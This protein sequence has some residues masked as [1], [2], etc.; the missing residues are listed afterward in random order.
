[1]ALN[2]DYLNRIRPIEE[3]R[4]TVPQ[5]G[6]LS[7][8]GNVDDFN[9]ANSS[10][11]QNTS[12]LLDS[13]RA[14]REANIKE[15]QTP[16]SE[17][18][19]RIEMAKREAKE[20][21]RSY[22]EDKKIKNQQDLIQLKK[23][24]LD[25]NQSKDM[26][27]VET[28]RMKNQRAAEKTV[29]DAQEKYKQAENEYVIKNIQN[30][31][32]PEEEAF[33]RNNHS[34][35]NGRSPV[36]PAQSVQTPQEQTDGLNQEPKKPL[37]VNQKFKFRKD[38]KVGGEEGGPEI[39]PE[40]I[41]DDWIEGRSPIQLDTFQQ[42]DRAAIQ[43]AIRKRKEDLYK[44]GDE[45]DKLKATFDGKTLGDTESNS[46]GKSIRVVDQ[47][48]DIRNAFKQ[49]KTDERGFI[50]G[51]DA[52][53]ILGRLRG[54][55]PY[56]KSAKEIESMLQAVVPNMA[57]GIYGEV[58]VLTDNDIKNYK[59]ILPKLSD[60]ND[61]KD[62]LIGISINQA[63]NSILSNLKN[64]RMQGKNVSGYVELLEDLERR[65][66]DLR[67]GLESKENGSTNQSFALKHPKANTA[68]EWAKANQNDPRSAEILKR[69][70]V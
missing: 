20:K 67:S 45:K 30:P 42:K 37:T 11:S 21:A 7:N 59:Q 3:E 22:L 8:A 19:F 33:L 65:E 50:F 58:G 10:L 14:K 36:N 32:D 55:N 62:A 48:E 17:K 28:E 31:E 2:F 47:L 35:L 49:E 4:S 60:P 34:K 1:M 39:S 56:D 26:A 52:S 16:L 13:M 24:E 51:I 27:D 53:P 6:R 46:L 54:W 69:L 63:R 15:G 43:S 23:I 5:L 68:L 70:G 66:S 25:Y 41:V 29:F 38:I 9:D 12:G 18:L 61:I 57:R 64:L 44:T 40:K